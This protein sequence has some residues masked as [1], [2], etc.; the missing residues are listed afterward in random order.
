MSLIV[1]NIIPYKFLSYS[2]TPYL[3]SKK[4]K[5]KGTFFELGAC[6]R[7]IEFEIVYHLKSVAKLITK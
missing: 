1:P 2:V 7:G 3:F 5:F 6:C 4:I